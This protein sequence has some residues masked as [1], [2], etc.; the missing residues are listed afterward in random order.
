MSCRSFNNVWF[1]CSFNKKECNPLQVKTN[2]KT[3]MTFLERIGENSH[4]SDKDQTL[5]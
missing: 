3:G 4:S 2:L 5:V 1:L